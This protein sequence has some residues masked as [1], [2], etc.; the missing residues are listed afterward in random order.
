MRMTVQAT[1]QN[2]NTSE[3]SYAQP[4]VIPLSFSVERLLQH[5][6]R[7]GGSTPSGGSVGSS[8]DNDSTP[9]SSPDSSCNFTDLQAD[10]LSTSSVHFNR[11]FLVNAAPN[12][13]TTTLSCIPLP[14]SALTWS[15]AGAISPAQSH[16]WRVS[17]PARPGTN[18]AFVPCSTVFPAKFSG[19]TLDAATTISKSRPKSKFAT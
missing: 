12:F 15:P 13:A 19:R 6:K 1:I 17:I 7:S 10:R 16:P 9:P 5:T 8:S 11:Q 14:L 18:A 3:M 2:Y 4:S